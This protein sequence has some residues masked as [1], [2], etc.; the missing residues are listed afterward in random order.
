MSDRF[1]SK[2]VELENKLKIVLIFDRPRESAFSI[3]EQFRIVANALSPS[4]SVVRFTLRGPRFILSDLYRLWRERADIYHITGNVYYLTP[5][6][7]RKR[8]VLTIADIGHFL[9]GLTGW[10]RKMYGLVWFWL[11]LRTAK[12]VTCTS[13]NTRKD[14]IAHFAPRQLLAT[15]IPCCV[16]PLFHASAEAGQFKAENPEILQVGTAS[17]KNVPR[18]VYAL[19]G[20]R[21]T[22]LLV[23]RISPAI[24]QALREAG[25]RYENHVDL[26]LEEVAALYRRC[27]LVTF[28]STGEGFGVPIIEAQA[29]GKPLVTSS[30]SPLR[31]VAGDG[32]CL[33]DPLDEYSMR[34]A[35]V[36]VIEDREYRDH[37]VQQGIRNSRKYQPGEVVSQYR[38]IYRQ[39][40]IKNGSKSSEMEDR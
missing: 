19:A 37:L 32:A 7:P 20:L 6:L 23:G 33:A 1:C 31:D 22:L 2:N 26:T 24:A 11:P 3:K 30:V 39:I 25:T 9:Y 10:R 38:K 13:E 18:L 29:S 16:S 4:D 34:A 28:I 17:Y 15:V 40:S 35:V 12:A 27:D 36:R 5:F 21:Y 8:V 14:L